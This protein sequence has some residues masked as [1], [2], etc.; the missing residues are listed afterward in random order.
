MPNLYILWDESQIWGLLAA[1][2]ARAMGLEH[3]LARG[4]DIAAGLLQSS[5]PA[6]LLVP[7]GNAR[8]KAESLGRAGVEAVR[9]YV[10]LGGQY[11]GFCGGAGLALSWS[12]AVDG[13]ALCPWKRAG[14]DERMQHFMSGHLH[15]S[16]A[17][18]QVERARHPLVPGDCGEHPALPVWWP[19]RFDPFPHPDVTVLATYERPAGDFWLAD[20]PIGSLPADIFSDWQD[21]YGFSPSPAFLRGQPCLVHGRHGRGGYTLSYSHLETPES[22]E[23]NHWLAHIFREQAGLD[24]QN[25][26]LPPWVLNGT[27]CAGP[28]GTK[29]CAGRGAPGGP[30]M[31]ENAGPGRKTDESA[32]EPPLWADP[33]LERM[34]GLLRDIVRTGLEHGLLFRRTSWLL[35]WRAG[36]PGAGLN[37][38]RA[39]LCAARTAEP[40]NAALDFLR[41][42]RENLRAAME[43][44]H[45]GCVQYLLAERLAM[46][47][48][49]SLPEALPP[50]LL[51][52]Q[53]AALFGPPMRAGGLYRE[54][55]DVL[56]E[57]AWL[58]LR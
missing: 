39:A 17:S 55:M 24:P 50:A 47:L 19:G 34:D 12:A 21:M 2:A 4:R 10:A 37:N 9:K 38:L 28:E 6:M 22:P 41:A 14:F 31:P 33:D 13:L 16:L 27:D 1:R 26:T 44:F 42:R 43:L 36:L 18:G 20:L 11:L 3:V 54:L 52:D 48:A 32:T 56:D 46:T 40:S 57:L 53:R 5:P 7:G 30:S 49:K 25:R 35:G 58:Q 15:V 8:H 29:K 51:R 23:A 45:K